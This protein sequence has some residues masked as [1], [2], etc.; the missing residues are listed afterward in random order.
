MKLEKIDISYFKTAGFTSTTTENMKHVKILPYLSIVQSV[1]GSYD[2][3][4]ASQST[5]QT[6]NGGFFIAP[7][8]VQQTIVHHVNPSSGKMIC[9]WLFLDAKVNGE[10]TLDTLYRFPT[11]VGKE[12]QKELNALFDALFSAKDLCETYS[13][14]YRIIG[15]LLRMASPA[16][17]RF[18][19]PIENAINFMMANYEKQLSVREIAQKASMSESNFYA[20]F[21]RYVGSSPITYLNHFRLSLAAEKLA[22][23]NEPIN[24]ISMSVGIRDALY[25]SKL[26]KQF[27]KITP[28]QYR[29]IHQGK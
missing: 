23:S 2:I 1:E 3:A 27:Y 24:T 7:S 6:G 11:L 28:Q 29:A 5:E 22:V 13:C 8:G 14:C 17:S 25:F 26:F 19:N 4:L 21:K 15:L 18:S 20:S 12:Y 16:Q 9:R 10:H